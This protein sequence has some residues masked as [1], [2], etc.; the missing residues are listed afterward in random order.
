[1]NLELAK[2]V[3]SVARELTSGAPEREYVQNSVTGQ[4]RLANGCTRKVYKELKNA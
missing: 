2:K 4:V 3:R 1:M